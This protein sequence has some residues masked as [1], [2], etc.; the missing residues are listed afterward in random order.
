[1]KAGDFW[2][3][4]IFLIL[5]LIIII[6]S[7]HW[8]VK[9]FAGGVLIFAGVSLV[10]GGFGKHDKLDDDNHPKVKPPRN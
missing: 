3:G 10:L 9:I 4:V 8:F 6:F 1:M 7:N 5:A 2:V